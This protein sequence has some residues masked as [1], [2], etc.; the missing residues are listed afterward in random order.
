[1]AVEDDSRVKELERRLAELEQ[2]L[3]IKTEPTPKAE[4]PAA[5]GK[6]SWVY[7]SSE[8]WTPHLPCRTA[9]RCNPTHRPQRDRVRRLQPQR[10]PTATR[11]AQDAHPP[12]RDDSHPG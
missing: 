2:K 6:P 4:P 12:R 7:V 8:V 3:E 10:N 5:P 11:R 1:M 9:I